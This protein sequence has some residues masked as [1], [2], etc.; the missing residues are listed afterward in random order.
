MLI[1]APVII[2]FTRCSPLA[3]TPKKATPGSAAFDIYSTNV[4]RT[5]EGVIV[6][7]GLKVAFPDLYV[8]KVYGRSGL[9]RDYGITLANGVGIIDSDYRGEIKLL[10]TMRYLNDALEHLALGKRVAQAILVPI[11]PTL[12]QEQD[13]ELPSSV[14]GAGGFGSTGS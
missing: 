8:L 1:D 10:F 4:E 3:Q 9:A 14:R 12:W 7:T 6:S 2:N 11:P 13:G 5:A